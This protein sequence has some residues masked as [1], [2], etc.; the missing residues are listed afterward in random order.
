MKRLPTCLIPLSK[1]DTKVNRGV[2]CNVK[3]YTQKCAINSLMSITNNFTENSSKFV[4]L[5]ILFG[6]C[7]PRMDCISRLFKL[8]VLI[9]LSLYLSLTIN[10]TVLNTILPR[11]LL[12]PCN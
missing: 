10:L 4:I 8:L 5:M 2:K 6:A 3:G 9:N 11:I 7:L 12:S 1:Q